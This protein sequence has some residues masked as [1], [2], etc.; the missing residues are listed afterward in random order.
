MGKYYQSV[1]ING[2][3]EG[4]LITSSFKVFSSAKDFVES[5]KVLV[6]SLI[7]KKHTKG[8]LAKLGCICIDV[9]DDSFVKE[10]GSDLILKAG[11]NSRIL[12]VDSYFQ[13]RL[14]LIVKSLLK[15]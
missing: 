2:Q 3:K 11:S 14:A 10:N 1:I 13:V 5:K 9:P 6:S 7:K 8:D 4:D 15:N 12:W